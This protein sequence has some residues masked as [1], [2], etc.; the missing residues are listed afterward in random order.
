[1]IQFVKA[2]QIK[3]LKPRANKSKVR[4][5]ILNLQYSTSYLLKKQNAVNFPAYKM[6]GKT[7]T[8]GFGH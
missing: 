3:F 6:Q 5:S 4:N 7:M 1:M 8:A 2:W